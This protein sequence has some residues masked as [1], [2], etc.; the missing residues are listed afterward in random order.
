M[1]TA[2][3]GI[4]DIV[5]GLDTGANDYL[6]K[7]FSKDELLSRIKTH[8]NLHSINKAMGKFVPGP[9]L[10]AIGRD[11]ITE[12]KLG[13]LSDQEVTV[14]FSDI[15]GFTSI[16]EDLTPKDNF[17][18]INAYNRRMGPIIRANGGFI[19]QYF[20]DG[21]MAIFP[22]SSDGAL[23]A[24]IKMQ[25]KLEEYNAEREKV[26]RIPIQVGMGIHTGPLVMGVTG[27]G[28]RL[29]TTVIADTVN[30]T[31]RIENLTKHY[32]VSV[33]ISEDCKEALSNPDKFTFRYLGQVK[34]KG[35]QNPN[36]IFEC[37]D[38]EQDET[39]ALKMKSLE[40]FNQGVKY[41]YD[42]EFPKACV[43]FQETLKINPDDATAK[44]FLAKA[45]KYISKGIPKD[46][47][48]VKEMA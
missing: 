16:S 13:D 41:F 18:L 15:R 9:F 43:A 47:T 42:Q 27:D 11:S 48:G 25:R 19:N 36:R 40:K 28:E 26:N 37:V 10:R 22:K 8:L 30:I 4:T 34:V 14:L 21:I 20:G 2:K 5:Q 32:G 35:K 24:S 12:V 46:W 29:N 7:P 38:G 44:L 23:L 39:M 17:K 3:T 45:G 6:T 1:V 31:S 33:L